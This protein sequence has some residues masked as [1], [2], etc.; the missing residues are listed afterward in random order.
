M[1]LRQMSRYAADGIA[2][3]NSSKSDSLLQISEA[4]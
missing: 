4:P 2:A 1:L 3:D